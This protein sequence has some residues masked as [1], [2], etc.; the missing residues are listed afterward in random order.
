MRNFFGKT[1]EIIKSM[2]P[3]RPT[4]TYCSGKLTD[5][6]EIEAGFH[7]GTN[8]PRCHKDASYLQLG[9]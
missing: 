4:C 2:V 7:L 8:E 5:P 1:I 9:P 6:R 3:S